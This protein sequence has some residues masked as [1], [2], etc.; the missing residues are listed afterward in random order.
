[1]DKQLMKHYWADLRCFTIFGRRYQA[2]QGQPFAYWDKVRRDYGLMQKR[3]A[4]SDL[5]WRIITYDDGREELA[6]LR[7]LSG[8]IFSG[9]YP[10][11]YRGILIPRRVT[12]ETYSRIKSIRLAF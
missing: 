11:I 1:M 2:A 3:I 8:G 6:Y 12:T 7:V 4:D 10:A 5:R 9:I